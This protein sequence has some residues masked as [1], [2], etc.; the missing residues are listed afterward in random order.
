[1]K[2]KGNRKHNRDIGYTNTQ[3]TRAWR[4][5]LEGRKSN[6][7]VE[8]GGETNKPKTCKENQDQGRTSI[9]HNFFFF[10]FFCVAPKG[11]IPGTSSLDRSFIQKHGL[12]VGAQSV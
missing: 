7:E 10:F 1:M 6:G 12:D 9:S 2:Q 5:M 3:A 11:Q 8:E 4:E